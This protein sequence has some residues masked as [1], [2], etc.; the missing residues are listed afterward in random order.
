MELEGLCKTVYE[1]KTTQEK[2][3][4]SAAAEPKPRPKSVHEDNE[5]LQQ[6]DLQCKTRSHVNVLVAQLTVSS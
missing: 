2:K 3:M 4:T 6:D 1:R 5:G